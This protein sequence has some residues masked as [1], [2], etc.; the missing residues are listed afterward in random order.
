M[1]IDDDADEHEIFREALGQTLLPV[2]CL[3]SF[4]CLS[5]IKLINSDEISTPDFIFMDW[6]L[7]GIQGMDCLNHISMVILGK[8]QLIVYS[9]LISKKTLDDLKQ[10]NCLLLQK[11]GSINS[12]AKELK[13]IFVMPA[14]I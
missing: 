12:L 8:C 2:R 9:G 4:D 3:F 6:Q 5:A 10:Y 7:G 13:S 11:S 14:T 1:L